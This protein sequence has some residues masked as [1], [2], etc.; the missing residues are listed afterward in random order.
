MSGAESAEVLK[1]ARFRYG[2]VFVL[3]VS[4]LVFVIVAPEQ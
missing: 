1:A 2:A 4:L 3:V